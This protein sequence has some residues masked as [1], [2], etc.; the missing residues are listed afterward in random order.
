MTSTPFTSVLFG[1]LLDLEPEAAA[2]P[3]GSGKFGT[4]WERMQRANA[5]ALALVGGLAPW[6][7]RRA[8]RSSGRDEPHAASE[9]GHDER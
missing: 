1:R 6:D 2:R 4:P 7:G 8:P 9:D 3:V 5:S